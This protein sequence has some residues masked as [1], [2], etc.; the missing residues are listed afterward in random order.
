MKVAAAAGAAACAINIAIAAALEKMI[1]AALL[2]DILYSSR[3]PKQF[4]PTTE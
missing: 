3:D 4:R 2:V 1:L